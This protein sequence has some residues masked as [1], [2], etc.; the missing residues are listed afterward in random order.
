MFYSRQS[1]GLPLSLSVSQIGRRGGVVLGGLSAS[2]G[3]RG[4]WRVGGNRE[5]LSVCVC[6]RRTRDGAR[7]GIGWGVGGQTPADLELT[8]GTRLCLAF[9]RS[10]PFVGE[11]KEEEEEEVWE[12]PNTPPPP[13]TNTL[14]SFH[15]FLI[16]I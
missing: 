8:N 15:S 12:L 5:N 7:R 3:R 16:R 10:F 2:V 13:H 11:E 14:S 1:D 9:V 6:D 4:V